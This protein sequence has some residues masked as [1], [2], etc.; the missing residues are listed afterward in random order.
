MRIKD[1]QV[2]PSKFDVGIIVARFQVPDLTEAH[3]QLLDH[4]FEEHS[5]VIV[6]LGNSPLWATQRNPLD[7]QARKQMLLAS[8]PELNVVFIN[9]MNDDELWSK[10]LDKQIGSLIHP[11]QTAVLYG[12]RD[13]FIAH[14]SGKHPTIELEQESWYS[15]TALR[16]QVGG[17]GTKE[18]SDFRRGVVWATLAR[19]PTVYTTVDI[20][21]FDDTRILL[22]RKPN[23]KLFRLIGGFAEPDSPSF[24][25]DAIRE[26]S[27]ETGI[28]ISRP[29][30]IGSYK[31]DD[32][33]Y[34]QEVDK[35]KTLLFQARYI[36]GNPTP[37]DDIE[38]VRWSTRSLMQAAPRSHSS[39]MARKSQSNL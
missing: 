38:E 15:G 36:F 10:G 22:G 13:S 24:E 14:Y 19:Y 28:E 31:I 34:R 17:A 32:W 39:S 11:G 18:T 30:Y 4:V 27:E 2:D 1:G 21:I 35:I 3:I 12:G 20:A 26:V 16:K 8:Y 25:A 6:F 23:E 5:K 29:E 7:F 33:R 37:G 9:D